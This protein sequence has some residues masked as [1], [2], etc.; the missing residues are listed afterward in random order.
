MA[1]YNVQIEDSAGNKYHP[2]P[3]L[4]T[5]REQLAANTA[6]GKS[7]DALVVKEINNN[8]G[9][10]RLTKEGNDFYII[11]ADSVR[12]KLGSSDISLMHSALGENS[13]GTATTQCTAPRDGQMI[14]VCTTCYPNG[15]Y[16]KVTVNGV[17][18][19]TNVAQ[20]T[21]TRSKSVR[22]CIINVKAGDVVAAIAH[23]GTG[24][25]ASY[26]YSSALLFFVG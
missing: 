1:T 19:N 26:T 3:D 6:A 24:S 10:C 9:G 5:T 13:G 7:V 18:V 2:K 11:G 23:N 15:T 16:I 20:E 21:P 17:E 14:A 4:L 12:K 8:L 22:Y 25:S